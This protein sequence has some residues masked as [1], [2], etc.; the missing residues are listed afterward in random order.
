MFDKDILILGVILALVAWFWLDS[1]RAHEVAARYCKKMCEKEGWIY[2]DQAVELKKIWPKRNRRGRY[3]WR[4]EYAFDYATNGN[5]RQVGLVVMLG[6]TVQQFN[7][8]SRDDHYD[9]LY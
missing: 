4:R 5:D 3:Q 1:M 7:I 8:M 6:P 2:L 9:G